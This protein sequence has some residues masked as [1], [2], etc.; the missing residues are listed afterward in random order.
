MFLP[1]LATMQYPV[2]EIGGIQSRSPRPD[3]PA[4]KVVSGG[5]G[6]S[7]RTKSC[8]HLS[9]DDVNGFFAETSQ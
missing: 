5:Y 8:L 3:L 7:M 6:S 4:G 1:S 9:I 2:L